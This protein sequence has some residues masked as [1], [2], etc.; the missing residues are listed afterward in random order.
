MCTMY[1]FARKRLIAYVV[2][3]LRS[4]QLIAYV[5]RLLR[6]RRLIE[7]V[8]RL[9][10]LSQIIAYVVRLFEIKATYASGYECPIVQLLGPCQ[11]C[12]HLRY[13]VGPCDLAITRTVRIVRSR[14]GS[15]RSVRSCDD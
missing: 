10:R 13:L 7:Y 5:V 14:K 9:F 12:G 6:S 2:R 11:S 1:V 15:C 3:I 4:R 8:L